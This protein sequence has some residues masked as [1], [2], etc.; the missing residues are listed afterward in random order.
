M[1][2]WDD[3]Y[4]LDLIANGLE[5]I[6]VYDDLGRH[7]GFS[8]FEYED[9]VSVMQS[10]LSFS[11]DIPE[12]ER[13]RIIALSIR[14][15]AQRG[16][17]T[18]KALIGEFSKQ[19]NLYLDRKPQEYV[20]V[21]NLSMRYLP[22]FRRSAILGSPITISPKLPKQFVRKPVID[23]ARPRFFGDFPTNYSYVR[24]LIKSRSEF[25]AAEKAQDA[26]DLLRGL[27]NFSLNYSGGHRRIFS[28]KEPINQI[29][30][31]PL[32]TLHK[33]NG[34]L[35]TR[36]Y[37]YESDYIGPLPCFD[38]R[39][40]QNRVKKEVTAM[41]QYLAKSAYRRDIEDAIRQYTRALDTRD[42]NN[43]FLGLWRVM[44]KLTAT[45][46]QGYDI[47]IRRASFL[48]GDSKF[49]EQ[50]LRHLKTYRNRTVHEGTNTSEIETYLFQIK[51][52]VEALLNFHIH[53][54]KVFKFSSLKDAAGFFD[55]PSDVP[56]LQTK[57]EELRNQ[58]NIVRKAIKFRS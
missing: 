17:I 44:E 16:T 7:S 43:A 46:R 35:A 10:S 13:R 47:T 40:R 18:P 52:Y 49:A 6:R 50:V 31:G 32:Q 34:E 48:W 58:M 51:H 57:L 39:S 53:S 41:R 33:R 54:C 3:K 5:K 38:M 15:V 4:N 11:S 25:E 28:K 30:L 20:L 19:E 29:V 14:A 12:V 1:P 36:D 24:V 45:T 9:F 42:Y 27:W 37:W 23:L 8:G 55:H 56:I 2:K 22:D 21:T 26:L